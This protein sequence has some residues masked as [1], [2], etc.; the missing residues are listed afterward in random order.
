MLM[1]TRL[2]PGQGSG[3]RVEGLADGEQARQQGE[4]AARRVSSK[5]SQQQ[6]EAGESAS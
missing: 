6:G 5:A 1:V 4:S 3:T 2:T